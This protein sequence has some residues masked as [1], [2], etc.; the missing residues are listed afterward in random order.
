MGYRAHTP[1]LKPGTVINICKT[2]KD[3][4]LQYILERNRGFLI[5]EPDKL[6]SVTNVVGMSWC[7]RKIAFSEHFR[8]PVDNI[9]TLR[10]NLAHDLICQVL[11]EA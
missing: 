4:N 3:E 10:G 9:D 7:E 5:V 6:I 11:I 1:E 2:D 8:F